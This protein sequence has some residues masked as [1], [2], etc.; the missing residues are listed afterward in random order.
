MLCCFLRCVRVCLPRFE[1]ALFF[2][3][4]EFDWPQL[5]AYTGFWNQSFGMDPGVVQSTYMYL[6]ERNLWYVFPRVS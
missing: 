3:E 4:N 1:H 6:R 2:L 5:S